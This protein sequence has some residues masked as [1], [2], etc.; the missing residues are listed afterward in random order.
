MAFAPDDLLKFNQ[1]L[2]QALADPD[3]R[4]SLKFK[5]GVVP[6]PTE[7]RVVTKAIEDKVYGRVDKFTGAAGTWQEWSFSFI[8]ATS[9][10]NKDIGVIL[11]RIG[12]QCETQLTPEN[13]RK[14]VSEETREK[15]GPELFGV[16]CGLTSGE[17]S[18]VVK[19][20]LS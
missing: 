20:V 8:N 9:G 18:S 16:L 11:E 2:D 3:A 13:L 19:R 1:L 10:V 6:P 12:Q 14:V 15:H 5:L 4:N 7:P 17:A